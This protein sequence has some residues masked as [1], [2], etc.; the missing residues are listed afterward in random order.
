MWIALPTLRSA[1]STRS[2]PEIGFGAWGEKDDFGT[3]GR[4]DVNG[5]GDALEI[6]FAISLDVDRSVGR[7]H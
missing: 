1:A 5:P 2:F 7:S 4:D 3:E 6:E